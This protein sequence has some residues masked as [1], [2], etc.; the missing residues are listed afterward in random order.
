LFQEKSVV[1]KSSRAR[2]VQKFV[3]WMLL[4]LA[5]AQFALAA[6]NFSPQRRVGYSYW[7][8][9]G[10]CAGSRR[11]WTHL[12]FISSVWCGKRLPGVHCPDYV[13]AGQQ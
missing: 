3:F 8:S 12:Y 6:P 13:A 7:R 5:T 2:T 11:A 10:T 9:M 1:L 4:A